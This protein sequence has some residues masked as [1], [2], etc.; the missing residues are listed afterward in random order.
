M[1]R[2]W[3]VGSVLAVT[4]FAYAGCATDGVDV[5]AQLDA[6]SDSVEGPPSFVPPTPEAGADG[7]ASLPDP[8]PELACIGR[9][10][11]ELR[12]AHAGSGRRR[13]GLPARSR[14]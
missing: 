11:S 2:S 12:A 8:E 1:K 10:A 6:G 5:V 7:A 13:R 9:G 4:L 14:A 3:L